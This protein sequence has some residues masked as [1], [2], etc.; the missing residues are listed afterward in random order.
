MEQSGSI[1]VGSTP[2]SDFNADG[3]GDLIITTV[4]KDINWD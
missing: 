1:L 4:D 3:V 2:I